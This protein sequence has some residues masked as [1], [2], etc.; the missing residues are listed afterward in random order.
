MF[1]ERTFRRIATLQCVDRGEC[2]FSFAKIAADGFPK[3]F[4]ASGEIQHVI[5]QLECHSE[6]PG[7][8]AKLLFLN[9]G[10][11]RNHNAKTRTSRK[12]ARG[13]AIDQ[14]HVVGLGDVYTT[15]AIELNQLALNHG[16]G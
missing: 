4:L 9:V 12:Q 1:D 14:F 15:N 3:H 10:P 8:F 2:D 16:L 11:T 13:L 6:I 7:K 5:D